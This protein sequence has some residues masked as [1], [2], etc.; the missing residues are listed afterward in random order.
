MLSPA[1]AG[2]Q[3]KR[4]KLSIYVGQLILRIKHTN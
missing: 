2:L 3:N 4:L 1:S